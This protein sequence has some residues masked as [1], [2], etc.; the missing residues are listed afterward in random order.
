MSRET[1]DRISDSIKGDPRLTYRAPGGSLTPVARLRRP[2]M[3]TDPAIYI[4]THNKH[5]SMI[6]AWKS[7]TAG[8]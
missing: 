5:N 1:A 2:L 8:N 6:E 7:K 4:L 3:I